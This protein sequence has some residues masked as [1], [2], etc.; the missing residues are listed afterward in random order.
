LIFALL[1]WTGLR[2]WS[3]H[4]HPL[5]KILDTGLLCSLVYLAREVPAN[6][7]CGPHTLG[8]WKPLIHISIRALYF[9][10]YLNT[11]SI[12]EINF[13]TGKISEAPIHIIWSTRLLL[14]YGPAYI[15]YMFTL[16][17][18][19]ALTLRFEKTVPT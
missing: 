8:S 14:I 13:L 5:K 18:M 4:P 9:P 1:L 7:A 17:I 12:V 19:F 6:V 3:I 2:K 10:L 16:R 15:A 11:L